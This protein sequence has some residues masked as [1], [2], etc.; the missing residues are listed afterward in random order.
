MARK[1][2]DIPPLDTIWEVPD[3]LWE[4]V[5]APLL[6]EFYPPAR[7]GRPRVDLRRVLNGILYQMRTGCQWNRLPAQFG[8]D[9]SV[10]RWFQRFVQD[11]LLATIWGALV[12]QCDEL[13]GVQWQWQAADGVL[14]KARF[15]GMK[16]AKTPRIGASRAASA[17]C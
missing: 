17:V 6:E 14:G 13:G 1:Q 11:G 3:P 16:S 7:T 9:S 4:Q 5:I 10:H 15:G 8:S 2:R 12:D